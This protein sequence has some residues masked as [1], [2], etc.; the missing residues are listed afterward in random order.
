MTAKKTKRFA[1]GCFDGQR[2]TIEVAP[3]ETLAQLK[4]HFRA[5]VGHDRITKV[6]WFWK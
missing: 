5:T 6:K 3:Q 2:F 1:S 4:K